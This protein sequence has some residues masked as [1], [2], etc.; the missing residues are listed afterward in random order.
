MRACVNDDTR[1]RKFNRTFHPPTWTLSG[2]C[3]SSEDTM[4]QR[5][6]KVQYR[7]ASVV[8]ATCAAVTMT[9]SMLGG[10]ASATPHDAKA[11]TATSVA[12][13]AIESAAAVERCNN[14]DINRS[15]GKS[16]WKTSKTYTSG[17][18]RLIL[19]GEWACVAGQTTANTLKVQQQL[20]KN[21]KW[22]N[23]RFER[24]GIIGYQ[25]N[26]IRKASAPANLQIG[27]SDVWQIHQDWA[28]WGPASFDHRLYV[29]FSSYENDRKKLLAD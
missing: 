28:G 15:K 2:L 14:P 13:A 29:Q 9:L 24:S 17:T 20:K 12:P 26:R 11:Y 19:S 8:L 6:R 27:T 7:R 22:K 10:S 18:Q 25:R 5:N 23:A 4:Q 21:G 1:T 16:A 3:V